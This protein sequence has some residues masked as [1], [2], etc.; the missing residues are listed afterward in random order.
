M[1]CVS[2]PS[3]YSCLAEGKTVGSILAGSGR[4]QRFFT[5]PSL[6]TSQWSHTSASSNGTLSTAQPFTLSLSQVLRILMSYD[7]QRTE[8]LASYDLYR[9][10][11]TVS[12]FLPL[13]WADRA[14][15]IMK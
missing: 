13:Q 15:D 4:A 6:C 8:Q 10:D 14:P 5:S 3:E 1:H 7:Y 12:H 2:S 9:S 11:A